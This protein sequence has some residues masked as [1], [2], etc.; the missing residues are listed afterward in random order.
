MAVQPKVEKKKTPGALQEAVHYEV[1]GLPVEL[2]K[3][4]VLDYLVSGYKEY[5][6]DAEVV[7]F[8]KIC[9]Y[10]GL[11]PWLREVYLIKYG[12]KGKASIVVGKDAFLKRAAAN[13]KYQGHKA[14]AVEDEETGLPST[15][16]AEVYLKDY[17]VPITVTVSYDEY[18][19]KTRD[20]QTGKTRPNK[21][22]AEKPRTM[23]RKVALCQALR[24][25]F[26]EDLGGL[27]SQEE[28]DIGERELE[29][30]AVKE[31][32]DVTPKVKRKTKEKVEP[33]AEKE[34]P[35]VESPDTQGEI[36][37]RA[38]PHPTPEQVEREL[39]AKAIE[40]AHKI[41]PADSGRGPKSE[42][43]VSDEVDEEATADEQSPEDHATSSSGAPLLSTKP[44]S[45]T[46]LQKQVLSTYK[47]ILTDE[48]WEACMKEL[49]VSKMT[50]LSEVQAA[51]LSEGIAKQLK[52]E[53]EENGA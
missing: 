31:A 41:G 4:D 51:H 49:D 39:R 33:S 10:R 38:P 8:L 48:E 34:E 23:L 2:T 36:G 26:P 19:Q 12:Q 7:M 25:A 44:G 15:G 40:N 3:R 45:I 43:I 5:V 46:K 50:E 53:R 16:M 17:Q 18:V 37:Y 32:K 6:T 1:G 47:Q 29:T 42:L 13:P 22:W 28:I 24:E 35:L 9:Y 52:H 14:W 27:Y 11:N 20:K 30:D 21:M